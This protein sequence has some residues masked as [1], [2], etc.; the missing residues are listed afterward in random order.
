MPGLCFLPPAARSGRSREFNVA[1]AS[2]API[3]VC[4]LGHGLGIR[5]AAGAACCLVRACR[6]GRFCRSLLRRLG[7]VNQTELA[8]SAYYG[9]RKYALVC[10]GSRARHCDLP[11][12][13]AIPMILIWLIVILLVGGLFAWL[14]G[15]KDSRAARWISLI[16]VTVD[17]VL[18]LY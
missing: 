3:L 15:R 12:G 7:I 16:A 6:Q 18:S 13:G 11:C 10:G 17:L 8:G 4:R 2:A 14:V 1:R 9:K 5:P